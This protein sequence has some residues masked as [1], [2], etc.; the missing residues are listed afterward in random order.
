M[1]VVILLL[2]LNVLEAIHDSYVI[3]GRFSKYN[4]FKWH[5]WSFIYYVTMTVG[6]L[7]IAYGVNGAFLLGLVYAATLRASVFNAVL[8]RLRGLNLF[9]LGDQGID[10]LVQKRRCFW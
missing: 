10:G 4:S 1:E 9:H 6:L 3:K 5:Q 8:N 7:Y 2:A